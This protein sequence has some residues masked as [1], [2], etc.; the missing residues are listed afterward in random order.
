[1][2][3]IKISIITT[4]Y[5]AEKDLPR[6]LESMMKIRNPEMEFFLIDNGSPDHCGEICQ[7]YSKKDNRFTVYSIEENIGYIRA[8]NLGIEKCHGDYVGFCD[9]DDF[10]ADGGYDKAIEKIETSNCDLY[11]GAYNL[12]DQEKEILISSP[13]EP[14]IYD[15]SRFCEISPCFFGPIE[16]KNRLDGFVWKNIY[17][18][19]I[20][21]KNGIRFIEELKPYEDQIFNVDVL[22]QCTIICVGNDLIYNYI[23]NSQSITAKLISNFSIGDEYHRI[24]L[25][26]AEYYKRLSDNQEREAEANHILSCIYMLMLNC[27]KSSKKVKETV[28]ELKRIIEPTLIEYVVLY[29]SRHRGRILNFVRF[30]LKHKAYRTLIG[31]IRLGLK[32]KAK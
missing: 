2:S 25:L 6:L 12:L 17:R 1:M 4:I 19:E 27:A 26:H 7:R 24:K 21:L 16:G 3:K 22:R 14:E 9:S 5:K 18:R 13:F 30:A 32:L 28:R 8:R 15:K 20:L 29:S 23:V 31:F 11:I 10:L